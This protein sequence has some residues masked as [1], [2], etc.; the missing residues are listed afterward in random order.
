MVFIPPKN[1]SHSNG[2]LFGSNLATMSPPQVSGES[3]L[4]IPFNKVL[5]SNLELEYIREA[6]RRFPAKKTPIKQE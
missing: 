6:I 4:T 5:T 2:K 3:Q 1:V